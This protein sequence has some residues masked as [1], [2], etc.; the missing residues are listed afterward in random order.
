ML[1]SSALGI[2]A[3]RLRPRF[4]GGSL[5]PLTFPAA[6]VRISFARFRSAICASMCSIAMSTTLFAINFLLVVA[7]NE[8]L[9]VGSRVKRPHHHE[10]KT[11]DAAAGFRMLGH[12]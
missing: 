2:P 1:G 11:A 4:F 12:V 5:L 9:N 10:R 8:S 7:V 6:S 3:F